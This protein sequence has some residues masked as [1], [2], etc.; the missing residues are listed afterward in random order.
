MA[1]MNKVFLMGNLTKDCEQRNTPVGTTICDFS[2]AVSRTFV[3][4]GQQHEETCFVEITVFGKVAEN[5][6]RYLGKGSPVMIE[7]R[8]QFDQ[9]ED[10]QTGAKRSKLRVIAENVQ[11][12][13]QR[14]DDNGNQAPQQQRQGRYS[15]DDRPQRPPMPQQ[16]FN[17][18]AYED[19][20]AF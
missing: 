15:A 3:K 5:C 16:A 9:W 17:P 8:L 18:D 2:L 6:A 19:D 4:D 14:K 11:F 12:L 13:G 20:I 1:T 10:R 7:G